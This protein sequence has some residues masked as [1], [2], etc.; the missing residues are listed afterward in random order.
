MELFVD[1]LLVNGL[2]FFLEPGLD[3]FHT[4]HCLL[5]G[6]FAFTILNLIRVLNQLQQ[7]SFSIEFVD[8]DSR[9]GKKD[10]KAVQPTGINHLFDELSTRRRIQSSFRLGRVRIDIL[11]KGRVIFA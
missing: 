5:Q 2:Y 11:D 4:C 1:Y 10:Y 3:Q 7:R 6:T 8:A 9:T